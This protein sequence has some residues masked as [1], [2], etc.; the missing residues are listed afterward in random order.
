MT[1]TG[2]YSEL[3][4]YRLTKHDLLRVLAL[5]LVAVALVSRVLLRHSNPQ[6]SIADL[7][8]ISELLAL[9]APLLW[10]NTYRKCALAALSLFLVWLGFTSI[11]CLL[12]HEYFYSVGFA[13]C[14]AACTTMFLRKMDRWSRP[15]NR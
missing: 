11:R 13:A 6:I 15:A 10:V 5:V 12:K 2:S 14:C 1:G 8:D 3:R 7:V 9:V 4:R